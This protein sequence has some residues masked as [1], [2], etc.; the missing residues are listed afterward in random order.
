MASNH[1][2]ELDVTGTLPANKITDELHTVQPGSPTVLSFIVPKAAPFFDNNQLVLKHG[3][4]N[5]QTTLI[6]GKDYE[7][8]H[9]FREA[10]LKIGKPVYGSIYFLDPN[11]AGEVRVTYQTIGGPYT[12]DD[13]GLI[14]T[15][16]NS[17]YKLRTFT[18]DQ[19]MGVPE[20]LPPLEHQQSL[21]DMR[22]W[23]D[24][25]AALTALTEAIEE[26]PSSETPL[27]EQ[28][29]ELINTHTSDKNNPHE[30]SKAQVG[31]SQVENLPVST[32]GSI[33]SESPSA[34]YLTTSI[35]DAIQQRL[36]S[37]VTPA[38][39]DAN[40]CTLSVFT[41]Q[42]D[43]GQE[44]FL[45]I[46]R[47]NVAPGQNPEELVD[48]ARSQVAISLHNNGVATNTADTFKLKAR[49][50][51]AATDA[52]AV[53][54]VEIYPNRATAEEAFAGESN[55][56]ITASTVTDA[57]HAAMA[58]YGTSNVSG[59][60][61]VA[62]NI[63]PNSLDHTTPVALV[64]HANCPD[65]VRDW[66]ITTQVHF[67]RRRDVAYGHAPNLILQEAVAVST[68]TST[69][70]S[71]FKKYTRYRIISAPLDIPVWTPWTGVAT[72]GMP[73]THD[74][75]SPL[76]MF[77]CDMRSE[78]Q[79]VHTTDEGWVQPSGNQHVPGQRIFTIEGLGGVY[80]PYYLNFTAGH[81]V[82]LVKVAGPGAAT[83]AGWV[84]GAAHSDSATDH[85]I[86]NTTETNIGTPTET[87]YMPEVLLMTPEITASG[88]HNAMPSERGIQS[89]VRVNTGRYIVNLK[90]SLMRDRGLYERLSAIAGAAR[91]NLNRNDIIVGEWLEGSKDA[92][93]GSVGR[94][95]IALSTVTA[96]AVYHDPEML[97]IQFWRS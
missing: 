60:V 17:L 39:Q 34:S 57:V 66:L 75:Q 85:I 7:L 29:I 45:V 49:Y 86:I 69:T 33:F 63:N 94:Q 88:E 79:I 68:T 18:W 56:Q 35:L 4:V 26:N 47:Y 78:N 1:L 97:Y 70:A 12:V 80:A 67:N 96:G 65:A 92:P 16:T 19:V 72:E 8:A 87:R 93:W 27:L 46:N 74:W 15:V 36:L 62:R 10:L 23:D 9:P 95:H 58:S 41:A 76:A 61:P 6:R 54:W 28:I 55:K 73:G 53:P 14:A 59:N 83:I 30:V 21:G 31:L 48:A 89:I 20:L 25:V 43:S 22:G 50:I 11:I 37:N 13:L 2:Y 42:V 84:V 38:L 5:S 91:A 52:S 40:T 44:T 71:K 82:R 24:L 64:K 90:Y 77:R 51:P 81:Y 32:S 3:P